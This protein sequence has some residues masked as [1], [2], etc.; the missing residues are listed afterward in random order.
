MRLNSEQ[1]TLK[2]LERTEF[3]EYA[4]TDKILVTRDKQK[5]TRLIRWMSQ[6]ANVTGCNIFIHLAET[7]E[8]AQ[9]FP[10]QALKFEAIPCC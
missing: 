6:V 9:N 2:E 7:K 3:L 1:R 5:R 8:Q 4:N 10:L